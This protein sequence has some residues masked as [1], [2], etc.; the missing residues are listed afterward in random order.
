MLMKKPYPKTY[1]FLLETFR[2]SEL[3]CNTQKR[4]VH[5]VHLDYASTSAK[6]HTL[7]ELMSGLALR[8]IGPTFE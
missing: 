5:Q 3:I 1:L 7:V 4:P 8:A 6:Q 2:Y